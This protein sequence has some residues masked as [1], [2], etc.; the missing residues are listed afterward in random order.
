MENEKK[1]VNESENKD[2]G[3]AI[4]DSEIKRR[5][6]RFKM[7]IGNLRGE[8]RLEI[9]PFGEI[10]RETYREGITHGTITEAMGRQ[11][12]SKEY[13]E[14]LKQINQLNNPTHSNNRIYGEDGIS[15]ALN[16][17]QGG[18]RQ[19]KIRAVLTPDRP[20]KRQ[21]GR[22][23]KEPREPSFTLTGQD[24]HGVAI[25]YI[26]KSDK[27]DFRTFGEKGI[28]PS[29]QARNDTHKLQNNMKIRR[30]TPTECERLQ[31]FPD[32]YTEGF[33]DTQRYKMMGNAVTINVIRAIARRLASSNTNKNIPQ[34]NSDTLTSEVS[35]HRCGATMSTISGFQNK[36]GDS[37]SQTK[38]KEKKE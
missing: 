24:I 2:V 28:A 19:P 22:R 37:S 17:A 9:L 18:N 29:L 7:L 32:G 25:D 16:T 21:N 23:F 14:S 27:K 1:T 8:P 13:I 15:P 35:S 38:D 10:N 33:S 6:E 5:L 26:N 12:S 20:E 31:G 36:A 11:G 34:I 4:T 3:I 30:L